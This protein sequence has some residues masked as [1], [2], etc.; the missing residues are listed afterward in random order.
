MAQAL[1]NYQNYIMK[2][3]DNIQ[4]IFK[5]LCDA[6][7]TR[8]LVKFYYE[9]V[10]SGK[11]EWRIVEP[12]ILGVKNN[13]AGNIFLAALPISERSKKMESR[14]TGHYLLEKLDVM[15]LEVLDETFGKPKIERERIVDTPT[16]QVLCRFIYDDEIWKN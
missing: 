5:I 12:Y 4:R 13:G 3:N 14:V 7:T 16:I 15:K 8:R 2:P 9:S 10:S 6:I 1:K 11:K